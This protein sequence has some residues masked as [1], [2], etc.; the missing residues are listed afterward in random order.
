M[1]LTL[2][3]RKTSR[4][5]S[6]SEEDGQSLVEYALLLVLVAIA[7]IVAVGGLGQTTLTALWGPI[8]NTVLPALGLG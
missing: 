6:L 2:T 7:S 4:T 8:E 5:T 3:K 1:L